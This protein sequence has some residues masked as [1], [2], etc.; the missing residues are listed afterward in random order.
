MKKLKIIGLCS[1]SVAI[2]GCVHPHPVVGQI[3]PYDSQNTAA[4]SAHATCL[5]YGAKPGTRLFYRCMKSQMRHE[6]YSHA[7]SS[8]TGPGMQL[9]IQVRC[10]QYFSV[11]SPDY[12]Q[13]VGN[14]K[15]EQ[16]AKCENQA[17]KEYLHRAYK[18]DESIHIYN[19]V[20]NHDYNG[21]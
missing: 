3:A 7:V 5:E 11:G 8:C 18:S 20:Y 9:K 19:H 6:E 2:S 21:G 12:W 16:T 1:L 13:Q 15:R 14:C 17:A 10:D 4:T